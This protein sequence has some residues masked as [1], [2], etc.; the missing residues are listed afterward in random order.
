MVTSVAVSGSTA[1]L[2]GNFDYVGPPTGSFV[3]ADTT[4]SALAS[5]WPAVGGNVYA[6]ASDGAGGFF[7]GG[8][9]SSI[10][11]KHA[12]NIAHIKADGTLDTAWSGGTNGT[13]YAIQ[14]ASSRVFAGGAFTT[15]GG[16][17]TSI[18]PRST[19]RPARSSTTSTPTRRG[20]TRS[21][22]R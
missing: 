14:V 22:P 3:A 21:W 9:F 17:R 15:A 20:R 16:A 13:V 1:Y 8:Q 2:G 19:R 10:G 5:P 4:S 18:S 7:I 6:A 12:D 11:T